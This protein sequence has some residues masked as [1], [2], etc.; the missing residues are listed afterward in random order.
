MA[1]FA[2]SLVSVVTELLDN[3]KQDTVRILGCQTLTNFIYSQT[4][5]TYTHTIESLV[6]K[7]CKLA[8]QSGEDQQSLRASSLQCLSAMVVL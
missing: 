7:V 3:S 2:V 1:C 6:H 4:D 8:R 5:C